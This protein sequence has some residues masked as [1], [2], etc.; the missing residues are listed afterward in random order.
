MEDKKPL[1]IRQEIV[2][3]YEPWLVYVVEHYKNPDKFNSTMDVCSDSIRDLIAIIDTCQRYVKDFE[4]L[5]QL[6]ISR[7]YKRSDT[8]DKEL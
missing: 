1:N 7:Q 4:M 3:R 2:D 5:K 6:T 8:P